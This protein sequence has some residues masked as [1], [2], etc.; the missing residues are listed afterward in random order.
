[1]IRIKKPVDS[2]TKSKRR[3]KREREKCLELSWADS[4]MDP[5]LPSYSWWSRCHPCPPLWSIMNPKGK[6]TV[7]SGLYLGWKGRV[8]FFV[9]LFPWLGKACYKSQI[10]SICQVLISHQK[11]PS[12]ELL[13]NLGPKPDLKPKFAFTCKLKRFSSQLFL[14]EGWHFS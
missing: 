9:F 6:I 14:I 12:Y 11:H 8:C 5:C 3:N 2:E 7:S 13:R 10:L 4:F 1:M